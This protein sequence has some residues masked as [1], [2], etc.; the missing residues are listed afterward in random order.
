MTTPK[1]VRSVS[2]G[3]DNLVTLVQRSDF[4]EKNP[5]LETHQEELK[6]CVEQYRESGRRA[7][8]GCRADGNLLTTCLE[9]LLT[10][11]TVLKETDPPVLKTFVEYATNIT[12]QENET[13]TLNIHYRKTGV[14]DVYKYE[15]TI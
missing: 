14:A 10:H 2:F 9:N 3:R 5:A 11:L 6:N 13:L 4:F 15:F 8:C 1:R 7:G 12:P